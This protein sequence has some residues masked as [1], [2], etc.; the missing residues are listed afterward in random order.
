[1]ALL[2]GQGRFFS[3]YLSCLAGFEPEGLKGAPLQK[4]VL[5]CGENMMT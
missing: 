3:E 5:D 4:T 2:S 1:M